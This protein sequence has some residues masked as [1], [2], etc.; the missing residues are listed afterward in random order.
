[1]Y[2]Y[3]I[4]FL[5][6][7]NIKFKRDFPLKY[8]ST[9]RIGGT[10]GLY[11]TP[12]DLD[13][14]ISLISFLKSIRFP[15]IIAGKL[16]N[17][18]LVSDYY[19]C[20]IS[21]RELRRIHLKGNQITA[22]GGLSLAELMSFAASNNLGGFE[23][24]WLIPG[25]IGASVSGNSGAHGVEVSDA[26]VSCTVFNLDDERVICLDRGDISMSYR[27]SSLKDGNN[28]LLSATFR[29]F[30]KARIDIIADFRRYRGIRYD[31][32]PH[33]FSLGSV[34][35]R[36]NGISAGYYVD[37]AGLKGYSIGDAYISPKHAGFILNKGNASAGDYLGLIQLA[38]TKVKEK[39]NVD[40][41]EEINL[42]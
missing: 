5:K 15:F 19:D 18:L 10:A 27:H 36:F 22:E 32:Q 33:G 35:K 7:R 8:L 9:V 14:M 23:P 25:S 24:L 21:T 40:L 26:L 16:S 39:F 31:S 4:G 12:T 6:S 29:F 30:D 11:I 38:K 42:V 17:T 2:D 3:I 34:F 13:E 1:M 41:T 20:V 37:R 28:V